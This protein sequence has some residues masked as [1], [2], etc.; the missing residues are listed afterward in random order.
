[1]TIK[2][3]TTKVRQKQI[4]NA[5]QQLIVKYGSEHVTVKRVAKAVGISEAAIYRHFKSKRDILLLL[6]DHIEENLV[7]DVAFTS[8]AEESSLVGISAIMHDHISAI[9][10]RHGIAHQVISEIVSLGDKKLNQRF[11]EIVSKY[12]NRLS[13]LI[14]V[15]VESGELRQDIDPR[16]AATQLYGMIQ[17][18]VDMWALSN[19]SF[20]LTERYEPLWEL[21]KA[22]VIKKSPLKLSPKDSETQ[23]QIEMERPNVSKTTNFGN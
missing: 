23:I 12:I 22:S 20:N 2:K 21:F 10:Q 11:F 4:I 13:G 1:M 5:V 19:F 17:G 3:L 14:T 9:E 18:L 8:T 7:G 16:V 6:A 15:C